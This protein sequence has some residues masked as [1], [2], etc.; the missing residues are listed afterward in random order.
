MKK[1]ITLVVAVAF[2]F[3]SC[4]EG[5]NAASK[6]TKDDVAKVESK[7]ELASK[8][9][10]MTFETKEFNFGTIKQ[11]EVVEHDFKFKNTGESDLIIV[12]MKGS[13]G[14]TVPKW[15]K[16]PVKPGESATFHVKFNSAGKHNKQN[17]TV[18]I[19]CNTATG[20]EVVY[21]K[22][23]VIAPPKPAVKK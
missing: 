18:T 5:G 6:I 9:P 2:S 1:V 20:K 19:T 10:V 14:C 13:C 22:G 21:V 3:A 23:D 11:G 16:T 12:K 4:S 17:K 8:V 15:D 7:K